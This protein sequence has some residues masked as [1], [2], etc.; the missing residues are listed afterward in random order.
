[1]ANQ[2]LT[3][4]EVATIKKIQESNDAVIKELGQ[5]ELVRM[6]VDKRRKNAEDYL[7]QLRQEE[8]TFGKAL[9]EKYGAG[10]I[11]LDKQEFIPQ[12]TE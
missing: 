3:K 2:K 12:E 4:E 5:I 7:E 6:G 9:T 1:M 8:E 10:S 11:D